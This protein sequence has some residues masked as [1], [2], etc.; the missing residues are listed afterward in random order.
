MTRED[1]IDGMAL[2]FSARFSAMTED[3]HPGLEGIC[4]ESAACS[5]PAWQSSAI[6]SPDPEAVVGR[7]LSNFADW[8]LEH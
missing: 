1:R 8:Q 5:A 2:V 7:G 3:W 6:P 4:F